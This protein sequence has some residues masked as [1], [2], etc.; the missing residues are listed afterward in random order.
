MG[1]P[2]TTLVRGTCKAEI[3]EAALPGQFLVRYYDGKDVLLAEE[4]LSG[5]S[6]YKQREAEILE[7]IEEL[8]KGDNPDSAG[9]ADSGEYS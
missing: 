2:L 7:R 1:T 8:C 5:V 6:T 9:L 4:E 3:Y